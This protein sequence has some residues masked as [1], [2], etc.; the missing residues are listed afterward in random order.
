MPVPFFTEPVCKFFDFTA[1]YLHYTAQDIK[2]SIASRIYLPVTGY[3][4]F[5]C[6][7]QVFLCADTLRTIF[8]M[9][10]LSDR[11]LYDYLA[12]AMRSAKGQD[13]PEQSIKTFFD[14]II[15]KCMAN[16]LENPTKPKH[17]RML[18][19]LEI[20]EKIEYL[21]EDEKI[22]ISLIGQVFDFPEQNNEPERNEGAGET[23]PPGT[24]ECLEVPP[25][26][27]APEDVKFLSSAPREAKAENSQQIKQEQLA[28]Y[29]Q[30]E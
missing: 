4:E 23:I 10:D 16:R 11:Q 8:N 3:A 7:S 26:T 24:P 17:V 1:E 27:Q 2:M 28:K 29:Q 22:W 9:P 15:G 18:E 14:I 20:I 5:Q 30:A 21:Q 6:V 25:A 13:Y 19:N 12:R